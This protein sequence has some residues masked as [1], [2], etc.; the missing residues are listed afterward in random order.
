MQDAAQAAETVRPSHVDATAASNEQKLTV[1]DPE[2]QGSCDI[3]AKGWEG[4]YTEGGNVCLSS[5]TESIRHSVKP[6]ILK[7]R[8]L[9]VER[10]AASGQAQLA[11]L[12][13]V[14]GDR[15]RLAMA[16]GRA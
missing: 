10:D 8:R 1:T 16:P 7:V 15:R 2:R 14:Q 9:D 4:Q 12:E 6:A 5:P 3:V 11:K 13:G